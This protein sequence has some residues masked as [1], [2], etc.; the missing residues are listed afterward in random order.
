MLDGA[1]LV[2]ALIAAFLLGLRQASDPDHLV[3]VTS[4][5]AA[6]DGDTHRAVPIG[7]P[8]QAS[9]TVERCSRSDFP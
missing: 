6:D 4:L 3:A 2:V 5:V 9:A 1:P 7:A 8:G